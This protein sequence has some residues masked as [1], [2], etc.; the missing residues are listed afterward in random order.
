MTLDGQRFDEITKALAMDTSRRR[1]IRGLGATFLG[2]VF[3]WASIGQ[4]RADESDDDEDG[5]HDEDDEDESTEQLAE[6]QEKLAECG[7]KETHLNCAECAVEVESECSG[8]LG[9]NL[10][11]GTCL[12]QPRLLHRRKRVH[13]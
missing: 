7:S 2:G 4:A 5:E 13:A 1:V 9:A 8:L 3:A 11:A 12:H 6:C 10:A